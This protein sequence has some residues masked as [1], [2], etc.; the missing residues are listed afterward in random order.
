LLEKLLDFE[1]TG[2]QNIKRVFQ[3]IG[4]STLAPLK[5]AITQ[6]NEKI[7]LF[8]LGM[9]TDIDP[10]WAIDP[11]VTAFNHSKPSIRNMA[12]SCLL[13]V[14][15]PA[16][17]RLIGVL[18][19]DDPDVLALAKKTLIAIGDDAAPYL[20]DAYG[21]PS[22]P[23]KE[24]ITDILKHIGS[25]SL[26]SVVHLLSA[27]PMRLEIGR[28]YL[29]DAGALAIPAVLTVF[30]SD[31]RSLH[32]EG[33]KVLADIY[34]HD[35]FSYIHATAKMQSPAIQEAY[36]PI[37]ANETRSLPALLSLLRNKDEQY[38][39]F[40]HEIVQKI[41]DRIL[42][43]LIETL[44]D[45]HEEEAQLVS[46]LL[47]SYG[48]AAIAPL[49]H[50]LHDPQL[51]KTAS[52]TLSKIPSSVQQLLPLLSEDTNNIAYYAGLA[53]AHSGKDG[54]VVLIEN[55]HD[56]DNPEILA[57]I[58]SELG[59][60]AMLPLASALFELNATGMSGTKRFFGLMQCLVT[61]ALAD[62]EYMHVLFGLTQKESVNLVTTALSCEGESVLDFL[63]HALM[64]W[65]GE[66]PALAY[67]I[68]NRMKPA[69]IEKL[70]TTLETI[71]EGDL[72]K[73]PILQLLV[74][75]RDAST[76]FL[77]LKCLEDPSEAIRLAATRDMG[78]FG[79]RTLKSLEK[80]ANDKSAAVRIAAVVS[81]GEIG[82]PA[83]DS[84]FEVLKSKE[85]SIRAVAIDGIAKIGEPAQIMLVQALAD[86]DR[87]VRKNVVRLLE[88]I[89]WQPK[90]TIDKLDYLFAAED[91]NGLIKMAQS[92]LDVLEQGLKDDDEE[93][94]SKSREAL[95]QIHE[96]LLPRDNRSM[97]GRI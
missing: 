79:R 57:R 83:L 52:L 81:M 92:A 86:K 96:N 67:E 65:N 73:I 17:P 43:S 26:D 24:R 10:L 69:A 75:L 29:I 87:D 74:S 4:R 19:S 58:L 16:V 33:R 27:D 60:M 94:R 7:A 6:P 84:L 30:D 77:L 89:S 38:Q 91:W 44:R 22:A 31:N 3:L 95:Q 72:R 62:A 76:P 14:G 11:L 47:A 34:E 45:A 49:I 85:S 46:T 37:I 28:S 93:I 66:T 8:S 48:D 63:L 71:P 82:I 5:E 35:P 54:V 41:G 40:T 61:L 20:V 9:I 55:F 42:P 21:K 64:S 56:D 12:V 23:P 13:E 36:T 97:K 90:Y 70:H 39:A 88:K 51:Q 25:G 68:C 59:P 80:A 50:A 53:V 1:D 15:P 2:E 32:K 78:T 18:N